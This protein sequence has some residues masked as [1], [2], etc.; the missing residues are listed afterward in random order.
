M[1]TSLDCIPCVLRQ[2]LDVARRV[3]EDDAVQDQIVRQALRIVGE[4]DYSLEPPRLGQRVHQMVKKITRTADPYR[5]IK[6]ESNEQ[7]QRLYPGMKQ[8]VA[9]SDDPLA[10]ALRFAIAGNIIDFGCHSTVDEEDIQ[11]SIRDAMAA[12]LDP[13]SLAR[14]KEALDQAER[15]LYL[16]DNAGEIVFDR[17]LIEE[18]PV[19]RV[20]VAVRGQPIINDATRVDA[21]FVGLTS[22]VRVIDNGS[23]IPGTVPELCSAGFQKEFESSDLIIAKGQGNFETLEGRDRHMFFLLKAKCPVVAR[24]L[25]CRVGEL[26][27]HEH[28]PSWK[29][30]VVR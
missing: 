8:E 22:L 3:T 23:D 18:L 30:G 29:S 19:R 1:Q 9:L 11:Q 13:D 26:V 12:P 5:R 17:L 14:F 28:Q 4:A 16:A 24:R 15:I 10:T 2:A 21:R 25:G 6:R 20:I 7:A 27:I